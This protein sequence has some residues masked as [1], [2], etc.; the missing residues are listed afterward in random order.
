MVDG[1]ER[2]VQT[3]PHSRLP[4]RATLKEPGPVKLPL[5]AFS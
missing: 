2:R 5:P 3:N 4:A 1:T